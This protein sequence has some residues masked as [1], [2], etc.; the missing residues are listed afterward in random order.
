MAFSLPKIYPI[1]DRP[2]SKL[3][4][5]EQTKQ[6]VKGGA[7]LIQL[8]EKQLASSAFFESA[9]ETLAF[10]RENGAKL[11][12]NDRVDI[13]LMIK[14]EGVHLG[15]DD[16]PPREAR[17]LLGENAIIGFSTHNVEQAIAAREFPIDY[18]A[19][20]PVFETRTKIQAERAIG[21]EGVSK[22]R[23]AI[24]SIPLVA[25]GG[26]TLENMSGVFGAGADSI[27]LISSLLAD[28]TRIAE[29]MA[30]FGAA[31]GS[32]LK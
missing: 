19:I 13:A 11:L 25:I 31:A 9:R 23:M 15:Q 18:I 20:G 21:L 28:N 8:R 12:I 3:T 26:I 2:L 14:A 17:R 22:A 10:A 30:V 32:L 7:K 29:E 6:L 5:L 4:H 1:T 27:A 16:F 24:G